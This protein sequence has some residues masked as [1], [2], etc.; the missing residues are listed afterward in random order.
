[1]KKIR[2]EI[3]YQVASISNV[4]FGKTPNII[5]EE[6]Q[7]AMKECNEAGYDNLEIVWSYQ[8][9]AYPS[10]YGDRDETE[11]EE[12]ARLK[13]EEAEAKRQEKQKQAEIKKAK[14]T[15]KKYNEAL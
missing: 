15:L 9:D 2:G 6:L 11:K 3:P 10:L 13:R 5:I 7:K 14:E 12:K 4:L 1:M 8:D